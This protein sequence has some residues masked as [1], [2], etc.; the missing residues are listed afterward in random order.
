M[1]TSEMPTSQPDD[2]G[3]AARI[4]YVARE[5]EQLKNDD[6]RV[7]EKLARGSYPDDGPARMFSMRLRPAEIAALDERAAQL[8]LKPSMLARNLVRAGLRAGHR[9]DAAKPSIE[10]LVEV[11]DNLDDHV[12]DARSAAAE[13]RALLR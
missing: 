10:R 2:G 6:F 12:R 13:V 5:L 8:R 3:R 11:L 7:A 4:A 1:T 9:P